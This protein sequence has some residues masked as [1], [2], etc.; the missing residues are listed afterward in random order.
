MSLP[1]LDPARTERIRQFRAKGQTLTQIGNAIG[2][3]RERVRQI[4]NEAGIPTRTP[5]Q[6]EPLTC[7]QC[8]EL[9]D[10]TGDRAWAVYGGA[11]EHLNRTG[12]HPRPRKH[13][14]WTPNERMLRI[15]AL[16][17]LGWSIAHIALDL[18]ITPH[19]I[20]WSLRRV[21]MG[22]SYH[23]ERDAEIIESWQES[24][25]YATIQAQFNLSYSR[26]RQIIAG[27]LGSGEM[28]KASTRRKEVTP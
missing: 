8:G 21:G 5:R 15:I 3:T 27:Y 14:P 1:I 24:N 28:P 26:V 7:S 12:H 10:P 4:C 18:G 23:A 20:T 2:L 16:R 19:Y 11:R 17:Q 25:S 6:I 13:Q 22:S 9:Y